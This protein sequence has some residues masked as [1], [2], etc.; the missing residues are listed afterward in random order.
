MGLDNRLTIN[1]L[2]ITKN[3]LGHLAALDLRSAEDVEGVFP[4]TKDDIDE[5][6]KL[7]EHFGILATNKK[8]KTKS[9]VGFCLYRQLD[10]EVFIDRLIV[11]RADRRKMVG[12]Q[13][14][15]RVFSMSK[16]INVLVP[17]RCNS[18]IYFLKKLGFKAKVCKSDNSI[19]HFKN[20]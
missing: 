6:I 9:I 11:D 13:L 8:A 19:Y 17:E 10:D 16:K 14:I 12:S 2:K 3:D 20:F 5:Y 18:V 7:P 15:E 1:D 4:M